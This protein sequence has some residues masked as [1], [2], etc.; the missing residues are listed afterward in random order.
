[1]RTRGLLAD[2]STTTGPDEEEPSAPVA[3]STGAG[4]R[5][6]T[7]ARSPYT[8]GPTRTNRAAPPCL[9]IDGEDAR[10]RLRWLGHAPEREPSRDDLLRDFLVV[11]RTELPQHLGHRLPEPSR[12]PH[13]LH[14][15]VRGRKVGH[16]G[17]GEDREDTCVRACGR[18]GE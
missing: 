5:P 14:L 2:G 15:L 9:G 7:P 13:P 17:C 6:P 8:P 10:I 1:M 18:H 11:G 12:P 3:S 4:S 16:P